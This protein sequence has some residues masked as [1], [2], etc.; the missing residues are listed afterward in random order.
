MFTKSAKFYD[1]LYRWKDYARET[2]R[3]RSVVERLRRSA[4][5]RLLD[6]A[7]GTGGHIAHLKA[8]YSVEGLDLDPEMVAVARARHPEVVFHVAE[9]GTFDLGRRFDVVVCLFSSIGYAASLEA[10]RG[11]VANMARHLEPGG[12]LAVEPWLTPANVRPGG[13]HAL[14]VD[15]PD[16][17]IARINV[18]TVAEGRTVFDFHYLVGAR[19]G[20]E[21]FTE[22]HEMGL[23]THD[24]YME[25]FE[26]CG[27]ETTC[28][29][30][31][32][33]GRGLYLGRREGGGS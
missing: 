28:D 16:L 2:E 22:H 17:K 14:F 5:L 13:L 9:M 10:M 1:A 18:S 27:L 12:V 24:Q 21:H 3:L 8:H 4:G 7:C 30:E 32:L 25:A 26:G 19:E 6:V 11:A 23:F 20:V 33:M 15:D 31:G 29:A